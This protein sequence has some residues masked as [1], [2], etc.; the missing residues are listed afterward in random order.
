MLCNGTRPRLRLFPVST[1]DP[2][3]LSPV[4]GLLIAL[5]TL[6]TTW[7]VRKS[8]TQKDAATAAEKALEKA[9]AEGRAEAERD[10]LLGVVK[11]ADM[12]LPKPEVMVQFIS[13]VEKH[14]VECEAFRRERD[15]GERL[16]DSRG[17]LER[18]EHER[19][20]DSGSGTGR[21]RGGV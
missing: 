16:R 7:F 14:I 17:R 6:L 18:E 10:R 12:V 3:S 21:R 19:A 2:A 1:P 15:S 8:T 9:K 20:P 13:R 4:W 11:S 5:A